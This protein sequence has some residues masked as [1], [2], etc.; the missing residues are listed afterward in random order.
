MYKKPANEKDTIN[1][2]F[3]NYCESLV[4]D[5][6]K[7]WA[8]SLLIEWKVWRVLLSSLAAPSCRTTPTGL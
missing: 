8:S 4:T 2:K 5:N 1:A 3:A 6:E 7:F